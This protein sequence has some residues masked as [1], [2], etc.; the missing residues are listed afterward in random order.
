[1]NQYQDM[2][3]EQQ[4]QG[5]EPQ[6][7][8][9]PQ[10]QNEIQDIENTN[11]KFC[12]G[13]LNRSDH[14]LIKV[15]KLI[16]AIPLLPL[17]IIWKILHCTT[18]LL[19]NCCTN[20]LYHF[21]LYILG[22]I[23][24]FLQQLWLLL[25]IFCHY[26]YSCFTFI[27]NKLLDVIYCIGRCSKQ[28]LDWYAIF[29]VNVI[30]KFA[31]LK[32]I[33]QEFTSFITIPLT[34]K[35]ILPLS[36]CFYH[37]I[38][39]PT[40]TVIIYIIEK[41]FHI[42]KITTL[43]IFYFTVDYILKPIY[44][45]IILNFLKF[46]VFLLVDVFYKII[47]INFCKGMKWSIINFYTYILVNFYKYL[48]VKFLIEIVLTYSFKAIKLFLIDFLYK[49]I[50]IPICK[51]IKWMLIDFLYQIIII[52]LY[53]CLRFII[54]DV[55][56]KIIVKITEFIYFQICVNLY[57]CLSWIIINIIYEMILTNIFLYI[58]KPLFNMLVSM[59][60]IIS[61]S[62]YQYLLLPLWN[63]CKYLFNGLIKIIGIIV[64]F[65]Y[66]QL[67]TPIWNLIVSITKGLINLIKKL[68]S[69]AR[70]LSI[71]IWESIRNLFRRLRNII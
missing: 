37:K 36:M 63:M 42:I 4:A 58:L 11:E 48:I 16:I 35:I 32:S 10:Q 69:A 1:M 66:F 65:I 2:N 3:E 61:N 41:L 12:C 20:Q 52:K 6:E 25:L 55:I 24:Q 26:M 7:Q 46:F 68:F 14:I 15:L 59:I 39:T 71:D 70:Q 57:R 54:V 9:F 49:L 38:Y 5:E 31:H 53:Q 17:V 34:L 30:F 50:I 43:T 64:S 45:Y 60:R 18:I 23:A 21:L 33:I 27:C 56:N 29:V 8:V 13:L 62:I 28:I 51:I 47:I 40:K 19:Y 67:L 44:K 22:K